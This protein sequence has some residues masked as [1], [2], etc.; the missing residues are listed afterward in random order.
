G[1]PMMRKLVY[2]AAILLLCISITSAA[3]ENDYK[4]TYTINVRDDGTA[5]WNVE[6]RT[7]LSTKDDLKSFENYTQQLQS[8]YLNEFK[9]LM[10][11]SAFEAAVA[12]SR[13]MATGDFTGDA[14]VQS[15][16][17]G[18]YGVVR[19]SFRWANFAIADPALNIGD[20]FVGGLYLSKD[21]T[22]VIQ[23]PSGY[24]VEQVAPQPDQIREGMIWY[25]LRSF[26][27]GEPKIVLSKTPSPWIPLVIG[28]FIIFVVG[29]FI[30]MRKS[31][32]P[33][34]KVGNITETEMIDLEERIIRLLKENGGSLY[35]SEIVKK[36]ALPKST[37]SS[38]LNEL[39]NKNLILK[40]K[41]GREN[42]VRLK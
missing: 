29:A 22:L 10:Q 23:Y 11:K 19:Y 32:V 3:P 13:S 8:V 33:K 12:T 37:V 36:L 28:A 41:K 34:E 24:T 21:N 18:K 1:N 42:L 39:N 30:Y 25:G 16:P 15:A 6:Y 40:I 27:A 35:Q 5:I 14:V 17:T 2:L 20:A 7:L 26:G 31:R 38:A 9:E 4:I